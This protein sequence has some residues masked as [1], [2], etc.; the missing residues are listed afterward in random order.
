MLLAQAARTDI[1]KQLTPGPGAWICLIVIM[2]V[3]AW[4]IVRFRA[5]WRDDAGRDASPHE[6]LAQFQE[7]HREGVLTAEEYRLIKCRLLQQLGPATETERRESAAKSTDSA[8]G[9]ARQ[10]TPQQDV[11]EHEP[12]MDQQQ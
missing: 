11:G 8:K 7:S 2:G 10:T 5:F 6:M 1:W 12:R 3:L 9:L 4:L